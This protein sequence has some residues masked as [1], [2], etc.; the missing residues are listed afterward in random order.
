MV[1]V[2]RFLND[3]SLKP[4]I[5]ASLTPTIACACYMNWG[6]P[7][8]A[9]L[10]GLAWD[11]GA[12]TTGPVTVPIL[13]A[14]GIGVI[15]G[16]KAREA[17]L[18]QVEQQ[19]NKN[20]GQALEG[21]G[22]ITLASTFPVLAVELMSIVI[23]FMYQADDI[24]TDYGRIDCSTESEEFTV[25]P[26][27]DNKILLDCLTFAAR[28]ILPLNIFM[29]LLIVCV[30]RVELPEVSYEPPHREGLLEDDH[31][32]ADPTVYAAEDCPEAGEGV[33]VHSWNEDPQRTSS[34]HNIEG[35][36]QGTADVLADK[37]NQASASVSELK[38]GASFVKRVHSNASVSE[39]KREASLIKR[40]HS[41][42][43]A[44]E[45]NK[46]SSFL[47]REQNGS[48]IGSS[49]GRPKRTIST[50]NESEV[51]STSADGGRTSIEL[52]R[53]LAEVE[54]KR[55]REHLCVAINSVVRCAAC[56]ESVHRLS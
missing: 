42:A 17:A 9:P 7:E 55:R 23:S 26:V 20:Q 47:R 24:R 8:L 13:L 50:T 29:V 3:W 6:H 56:W 5:A 10:I 51:G 28:S 11:C 49:F 27:D 43:S 34:S 37:T 1:G 35:G 45:L 16:K 19:A 41:N 48:E 40:S 15:K 21:F 18:N 54:E 25:L 52:V 2:L 53:E 33:G 32:Y 12:V 36:R 46:D 38:R 44:S 22:V 4:L 30:L 14:I 31:C 39:L